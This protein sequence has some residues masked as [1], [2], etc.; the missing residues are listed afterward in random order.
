MFQ[1]TNVN[2]SIVLVISDDGTEQMV[3]IGS[4]YASKVI[5]YDIWFEYNFLV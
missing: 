5:M 2:V 3:V 4:W 1:P